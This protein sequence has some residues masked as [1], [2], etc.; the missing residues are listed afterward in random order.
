MDRISPSEG[1]GTGSIPVESTGKRSYPKRVA[2]LS[3]ES[4]LTLRAYARPRYP[5]GCMIFY[6]FLD[7]GIERRSKIFEQENLVRRCP[8]HMRATASI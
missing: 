4:A 8:D 3:T 6:L 2:S 1:G 5:F 7:R